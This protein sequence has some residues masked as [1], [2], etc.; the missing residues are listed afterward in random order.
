MTVHLA[1]QFIQR[2]SS[3]LRSRQRRA[4]RARHIERTHSHFLSDHHDRHGTLKARR[5]GFRH[6]LT[7][8]TATG[9][10]NRRDWQAKAMGGGVSAGGAVATMN[11]TA[12]STTATSLTNTGA[13]FPTA[14]QGLA[15]MIVACGPNASGTGATSFGVIV[16]NSGTV[17]TIDQWY[18]AGTM[19]VGTTP[20]GTCKYQVLPGQMPACFL[21][22]TA[23]AVAP[24]ASDTTLASEA[25]T[26]G[27]ARALGT[28]AHTA[29][30]S[31]YTLQ[32]VFTATG[33]L[34]VNKEAV[35]AAANPT[36]GGA[37]PFESAEPSPPVLI[38]GDTL[39][40]TVTVTI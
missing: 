10:T 2:A 26:N 35:F 20:N 22:V 9:Y 37:M 31:T 15:G 4:T 6:N 13:S 3:F 25:T 36:G 11:G 29:A 24:A 17:L 14:G 39:T 23:D 18:D 40:Q 19:A 32:K 30:A 33:S 7:T 16:S 5:V 27:F 8:D 28:F 38:S 34:T 21:A 12:T 1:I